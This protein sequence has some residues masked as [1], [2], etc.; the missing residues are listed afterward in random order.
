MIDMLD[1]QDK[2]KNFSEAQLVQEMQRPTGSAPQ[3]MVLSEIERRKRMRQEAQRQQGMNQP[4]V[5]QEA[6]AAAG[7]PQQGIAQVARSL[8]PKTDMMQNTGAS[9]MPQKMAEGGYISRS[10]GFGDNPEYDYAA[11]L[12][13]MGLRDTPDARDVF[14]RYQDRMNAEYALEGPNSDPSLSMFR[15]LMEAPEQGSPPAGGDGRGVAVPGTDPRIA[16]R[17]KVSRFGNPALAGDLPYVAP[18]APSPRSEPEAPATSARGARSE[19]ERMEATS[20]LN[21]DLPSRL[22]MGQRGGGA[23]DYNVF[24]SETSRLSAPSSARGLPSI[25]GSTTP[26]RPQRTR[27]EQESSSDDLY[28]GI[29]PLIVD[30]ASGIDTYRDLL[31]QEVRPTP[32]SIA[33]MTP[34]QRKAFEAMTPEEQA[35]VLS[36]GVPNTSDTRTTMDQSS[37][38]EGANAYPLIKPR[39]TDPISLSDAADRITAAI[40]G[41][42]YTGPLP[43]RIGDTGTPLTIP[44]GGIAELM[45]P[46]SAEQVAAEEA[47]IVA[48]AT[49]SGAGGGSGGGSGGGGGGGGGSLDARIEELIANR[50]AQADQDKWLALAQVGLSL[51]S[52]RDIGKAGM[53][54]LSALQQSRAGKEAFDT[55][56]LKLQAQL[57]MN[58]ARIAAAGQRGAERKPGVTANEMRQLE[59]VDS[60][61]QEAQLARAAMYEGDRLTGGALFGPDAGINDADNAIEAL[62]M[63]RNALLEA[64]GAGS[65]GPVSLFSRE[66][67]PPPS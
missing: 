56:M 65:S 26:A 15:S 67:V 44:E 22:L 12:Q 23:A 66:K 62:T 27:A 55:D 33:D 34:A 43:T 57:D 58:R 19:Q 38:F 61:L 42:E 41:T 7:V 39:F 9:P 2:L 48:A 3:F 5:A 45:P 46:K 60:Q 64:L 52:D 29:G 18:T 4:T 50:E 17:S 21:L 63:R 1:T 30:F 11:F 59:L 51:M 40:E 28:T 25:G 53:A 35:N 31:P 20:D 10:S 47:A 6:V 16:A 14:R 49:P 24:P 36:Y 13:E 54:G 37:A 8:A 32:I